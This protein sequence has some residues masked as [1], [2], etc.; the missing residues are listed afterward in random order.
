M[1]GWD[2]K[3]MD[4]HVASWMLRDWGIFHEI[5]QLP[6]VDLHGNHC[7]SS[8]EFRIENPPVSPY[9]YF[10]SHGINVTAPNEFQ[11]FVTIQTLDGVDH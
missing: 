5:I 10:H 9:S 4:E 8:L 7:L 3:R 11:K 6:E 1:D 2:K